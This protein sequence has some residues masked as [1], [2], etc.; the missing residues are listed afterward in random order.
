MHL[1]IC[2]HLAFVERL[3]GHNFCFKKEEIK[4]KIS[5]ERRVYESI[6][7]MPILGY[8]SKFDGQKNPGTNG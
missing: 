8:T 5:Y 3:H 2:A 6:D 1:P 7:D 4:E